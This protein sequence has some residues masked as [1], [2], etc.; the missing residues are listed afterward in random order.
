MAPSTPTDSTAGS[1]SAGPTI[2][3]VASV[4]D[5]DSLEGETLT[6][7]EDQVDQNL[8]S[9]GNNRGR[10][11]Q[12]FHRLVLK[13]KPEDIKTILEKLPQMN[14]GAIGELW[15]KVMAMAQ[16]LRDP[17]AAWASKALAIAALLYLVSPIDAVPDV[18]PIAGLADDA[19]LILSVV[20]TLAVQLS[21]YMKQSDLEG[22]ELE[23]AELAES[24]LAGSEQGAIDQAP[25]IPKSE[26]G[27]KV[28][29]QSASKTTVVTASEPKSGPLQ[30][31]LNTLNVGRS[32]GQNLDKG[33]DRL[34][35]GFGRS[36]EQAEALADIEVR[37]YNRI[38][39]TTLL[40]SL[41]AAALAIGVRLIM[42]SL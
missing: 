36:L 4:L 24:E 2:D 30:G 41:A 27:A 19:A 15:P 39:R 22:S 7:I 10:V 20:S 8:E 40:G 13:A 32:L 25:V 9:L 16:L 26:P 3:T 33:L 5:G 1:Y 34:E 18:I 31:L 12:L 42:K 35:K 14:R 28:A 38:V 37:K 29:V 21:K 11:R 6:A 17:K 23:G